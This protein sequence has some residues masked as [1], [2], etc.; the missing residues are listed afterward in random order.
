MCSLQRHDEYTRGALDETGADP[1]PFRQFDAWFTDAHAANIPDPN[2]MTV[3]TATP[4]GQPAARIVL[5][6]GYD[7]RGFVFYTNYESRKGQEL[8]E[9][10]VAAIVFFWPALERQIRITGAV[11][12]AS[13]DETDRYFR[14]RPRGSRLGAWASPQSAVI[15]GRAEIE[16]RLRGL[17]QQYPGDDIPAPPHWGGYRVAPDAFEFWQGR[18]SR[19]HD[20][21]RYTR[22]PDGSWRIDRLAP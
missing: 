6:R 11:V 13:R 14:G 10:P 1:N 3:A 7:E 2:A 9:N 12:Q 21:L 22:Q 17:E 5:L 16:D 15:A 19:L 20:R 4:D 8:A 18:P